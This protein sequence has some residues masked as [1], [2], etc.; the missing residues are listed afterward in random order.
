MGH[1]A[2]L[3]STLVATALLAGVTTGLP[4]EHV[5]AEPREAV[6]DHSQPHAIHHSTHH[7]YPRIH[8]LS[9]RPDL[10]TGGSALVGI[11]LPR[12]S[13]A[14]G[15]T[16]HVGRRL[17]THRFAYRQDGRFEGL[18]RNLRG[19][20]NHLRVRLAS[21][22]G[23]RLTLTNH[24]N[25][26]PLF[27]GPQLEP[28]TCQKGARGAQ[29]N[30][31]S[32]YA[33]SYKSTNPALVGFQPYDAAKPPS[34]VATTTTDNGHTVPFIVRTETG[35]MDRD[36]YQISALYQPGKRW[37]A[38]VPQPQF[39]HK[40]LITHGGSC[41]AD[42][43][44]GAAPATTGDSAGDVALGMGYLVMS[45]AL[46]NT[47]HN[48]NL[49]VEAESLVMAKQHIATSYG[50]LSFTIGTG[51]SGGSL[52]QQWIANAY[53]G[54]YQGILP[55]CSFPD[56]YST[57][58]QFLDYHLLLAYF[59]HPT[60]WDLAGGGVWS[61]T[62]MNDV[63]GGPDGVANAQVSDTAQ[64][65]VVVPTDSCL[66]VA[67]ARRYSQ[68]NAKGIRCTIQDAAINVFGPQPRKRWSRPERQAGR[69][70][71]R[72][73]VDNVGVQYGLRSLERGQISAAQFVDLNAKI[74]GLDID[75]QPIRARSNAT[76][77]PALA[78]AYRTGMINEA[79]NLGRTAIIDC[80]GPNPG[81]FHDAYR[82]FAVRAR[83][84]RAN[85]THANQVI[86]EGVAPLMADTNCERFSFRA[87][88]QWLTR[89][90]EDHRDMPL[91][92]KIIAD[93]PAAITDR[94]YDGVGQQLLAHLCPANVVNVEPT[95][96]Q[97][98]GDDIT[99]DDNKCQLEPLD[100]RN[101][102]SVRFTDAQWHRVEQTF[103]QGVCNFTKPG[104]GQQPTT[105][106]L[107]YQRPNGRVI[108]GGRPLGKAPRSVTVDHG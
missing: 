104:I 11:R 72:L 75:G 27:S 24:P 99:N 84:D 79:T 95:P 30:A 2:A 37:T 48:C 34:D 21:G 5:A 39:N 60:R 59:T 54:I 3:R 18:I 82:A 4:G 17:I 105:P 63:L 67:P 73:P 10:V 91:A 9:G 20:A 61:P 14:H 90:S 46:D 108:F 68:T 89:V 28:W 29:C 51:C 47:G 33:F 55:A 38:L 25:G 26:G 6:T 16:V 57:A 58:T 66:G 83:L 69:G 85:G 19:G 1:L 101:Y 100:R 62:Q 96:R 35:Y 8:V 12:R 70:F 53:P 88:D 31:P 97:I 78:R 41:G 64:W 106:W 102:G 92:R 43:V 87:M 80:R 7:G 86:W 71:V 74:G 76:G 103:P 65:H 52:A 93:K 36:Q 15:L 40:L 13:D 42:H 50:T 49:V 22:K 32:T 44:A 98:A 77:S 94:C 81:L 45:T 23:A 56:A 107:T